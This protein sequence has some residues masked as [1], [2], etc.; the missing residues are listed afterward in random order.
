MTQTLSTTGWDTGQGRRGLRSR[1]TTTLAMLTIAGGCWLVPAVAQDH[2]APAQPGHAPA[3]EP[4]HAPGSTAAEPGHAPAPGKTTAEPG[5][6]PAPGNTTTEPGHAP[7]TEHTGDTPPAGTQPPA[8]GHAADGHGEA[9]HGEGHG[10]GEGE[11]GHHGTHI[12]P[13]SLIVGPL[14]QFW[15]AGP[16]T[17]NAMGAVDASGNLVKADSFKGQTFTYKHTDHEHPAHDKPVYTV[18]ATL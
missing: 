13:P 15:Y 1:M 6:A 7:T 12:E 3:A 5:H 16:A 4:G 2:A 11:E 17:V 10:E 18:Q 8:A 14:K 9:G